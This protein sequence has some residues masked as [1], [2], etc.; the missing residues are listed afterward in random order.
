[1]L[2][3]KSDENL[4]TI[5][6]VMV[7]KLSVYFSSTWC[8][9][10]FILQSSMYHQDDD[11]ERTRDEFAKDILRCHNVYRDKHGSVRWLLSIYLFIYLITSCPVVEL[12]LLLSWIQFVNCFSL[13]IVI[14]DIH[15]PANTSWHSP[16]FGITPQLSMVINMA[17]QKGVHYR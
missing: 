1:M 11:D 9:L 16:S 17:S 5:L 14:R 4:L 2:C 13:C 10:N 6:K 15:A 3:A 8:V 12:H 7:K